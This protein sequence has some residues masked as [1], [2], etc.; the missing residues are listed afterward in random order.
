MDAWSLQ[1]GPDEQ[2]HKDFGHIDA[3]TTSLAAHAT[4]EHTPE[5]VSVEAIGN[6]VIREGMRLRN[7]IANRS[8]TLAN[9]FLALS[10]AWF[11]AAFVLSI[12]ENSMGQ[13]AGNAT[14]K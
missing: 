7:R 14:T 9:D 10:V 3:V 6:L 5:I 8:V 1:K 4:F 13:A 11:L 2:G 12:H